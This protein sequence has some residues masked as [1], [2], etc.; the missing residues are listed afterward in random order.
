M[1]SLFLFVPLAGRPAEV[2]WN[3]YQLDNKNK[4]PI[5]WVYVYVYVYTHTLYVYLSTKY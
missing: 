3:A 2:G 1:H 4:L 5:Y